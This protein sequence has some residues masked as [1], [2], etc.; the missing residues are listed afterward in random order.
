MVEPIWIAA[1][2]AQVIHDDQIATHGGAYGLRDEGLLMK[3]QICIDWQQT[4]AMG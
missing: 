3:P 1:V 2:T 4:M